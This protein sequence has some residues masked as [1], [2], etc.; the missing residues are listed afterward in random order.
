MA[1]LVQTTGYRD[2]ASPSRGWSDAARNH[3]KRAAL[4]FPDGLN[5]PKSPSSGGQPR[6]APLWIGCIKRRKL[7]YAVRQT[8]LSQFQVASVLIGDSD[9]PCG[10]RR[11][12]VIAILTSL[13]AQRAPSGGV[14]TQHWSSQAPVSPSKAVGLGSLE[15]ALAIPLVLDAAANRATRVQFSRCAARTTVTRSGL[16][17]VMDIRLVMSRS[18]STRVSR[19]NFRH[20]RIHPRCSLRASPS[21]RRHRCGEACR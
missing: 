13:T 17:L 4:L 2:F 11:G 8:F 10:I 20:R 21:A 9:W 19:A 12:G 14:R 16:C 18:A 3:F 15:K 1:Q 7:S 5:D 6:R